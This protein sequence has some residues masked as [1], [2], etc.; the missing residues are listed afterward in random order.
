MRLRINA[1][2]E[3]QE[4]KAKNES[5]YQFAVLFEPETDIVRHIAIIETDGTRVFA[6]KLINTENARVY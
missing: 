4:S 2:K 1:I 6:S 5:K 3:I